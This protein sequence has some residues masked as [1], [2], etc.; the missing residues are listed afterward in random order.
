MRVLSIFALCLLAACSSSPTE[1]GILEPLEE[2]TPPAG[3]AEPAPAAPPSAPAA[4]PALQKLLDLFATLG[5]EAVGMT[6]EDDAT[7]NLLH[8]VFSDPLAANRAIKLVY[9]GHQMAYDA[10]AQSLTV[11]G[12]A[13]AKVILAY[14][15]KIPKVKAQ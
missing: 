8:R 2:K 11:G 12:S 9:T 4:S 5:Y 15:K 14:L 3:L 10:K 13:D 6:Y 7:L 1:N